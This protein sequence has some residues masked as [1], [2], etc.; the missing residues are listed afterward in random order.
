MKHFV[1]TGFRVAACNKIGRFSLIQSCTGTRFAGLA[2][3]EF[4]GGVRAV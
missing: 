3:A 2:E 1:P 4:T